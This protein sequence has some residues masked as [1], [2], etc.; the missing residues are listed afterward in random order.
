MSMTLKVGG[1]AGRHEM[2]VDM[3]L[4]EAVPNVQNAYAQ[5]TPP[6]APRP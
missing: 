4:L 5:M 3:F 1:V 2:P 6:G